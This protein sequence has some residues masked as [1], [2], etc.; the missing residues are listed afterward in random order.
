MKI[1]KTKAQSS[2]IDAVEAFY[3]AFERKEMFFQ[4]LDAFSYMIEIFAP[5]GTS[6]Y[7][8]QAG[9]DQMNIADRNQVVG[10]YNLLKDPVCN[11]VLGLR[12]YI[13]RAF[14]GE[15]C[16]IRDVRI[17]YE[18]T[19]TRY[20]K[21]DEEFDQ[22]AY[23]DISSFPLRD[24]GGKIAYIVMIFETKHIYK[25]KK[26]IVKAQEY[27]N[28]HW[29]DNYD[30][31]KI[32]KVASLSQSRFTEL[33]KKYVNETPFGYYKRIKVQKIKEKLL[34][35]NLNVKEAFLACGVDYDGHYA[36][37]FQEIVGMTPKK[38]IEQKTKTK[39]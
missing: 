14:S 3:K 20:D 39:S 37:V 9:L 31:K 29:R 30:I 17:P 6:V 7:C 11:D 15:R 21:K 2:G 4:F 35:P 33:F 25:G 16:S 28:E 18:D 27:I 34:D 22:A 26:E 32:A 36:K 1:E 5:D 10:H 13:G 19:G 12:E 8:N 24:D 23:T 38:F